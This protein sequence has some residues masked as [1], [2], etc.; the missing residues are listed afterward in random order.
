METSAGEITVEILVPP[1]RGGAL[2]RLEH[3]SEYS[4]S[5]REQLVSVRSL[6][7]VSNANLQ[8]GIESVCSAVT[9]ALVKAAPESCDVEFSL[10][11]KAGAKVP[12]LMAGE[13][14]GSLK[15][16]LRWKRATPGAPADGSKP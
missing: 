9:A 13:A 16:T 10:G 4:S 12:V 2:G 8:R 5:E 1:E 6:A 7:E 15:V 3:G 14:N 11:F